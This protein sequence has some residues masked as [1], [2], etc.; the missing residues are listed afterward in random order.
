[1]AMANCL[2]RS[3]LGRQLEKGRTSL[4]FWISALQTICLFDDLVAEQIL[5]V[6]DEDRLCPGRVGLLAQQGLSSARDSL[7]YDREAGCGFQESSAFGVF[8]Y[9]HQFCQR[10]EVLI[11]GG[12]LARRNI[13]E[14]PGIGHCRVD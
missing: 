3:A 6:F 14:Q 9:R 11:V 12:I 5:D 4:L 1:M 13:A 10:L 8:K 7:G 2:E